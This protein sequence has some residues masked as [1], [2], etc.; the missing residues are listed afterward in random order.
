MSLLVA[1]EK[2]PLN[3]D[4]DGVV[5]I[6]GTRVTLETLV[7]A[8][9]DGVSAEGIVEQYPS[10]QLADVYSVIGY[11]LHHADDVNAYLEWRQAKAADVRRE[12]ERQFS[13]VGVRD[14]LLARRHSG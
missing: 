11:I 8:F 2:A 6:G 4:A 5:R 7:A 10:L 1:P 3:A 14:R 12:N 9:R 13:P